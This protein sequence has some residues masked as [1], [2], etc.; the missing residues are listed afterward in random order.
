MIVVTYSDGTIGKYRDTRKAEQ[1]I[2]ETITGCDF[3]VQVQSIIDDD[4]NIPLH[5][6]WQVHLWA[7]RRQ[8]Q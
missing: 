5:C 4:G 8:S 2:V 1:E 6:S 7:N 3:A